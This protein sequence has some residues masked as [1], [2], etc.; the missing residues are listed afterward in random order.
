MARRATSSRIRPTARPISPRNM[1][2]GAWPVASPSILELKDVAAGYG[3]IQV[4]WGIDLA[5]GRGE[6]TALIG[7]NG[8]GKTTLMR[9]SSGLVPMWAGSCVSEG[10]NLFGHKAADML[11]HGIVHVPEGRRL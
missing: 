3:E 2:S 4:L 1:R 5:V 11:A 7:S 10:E 9:G 6:I 8:A